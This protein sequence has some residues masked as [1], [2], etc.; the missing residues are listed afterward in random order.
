MRLSE[1]E[2]KLHIFEVLQKGYYFSSDLHTK[3]NHVSGRFKNIKN[4][5]MMQGLIFN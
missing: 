3:T 2:A 1:T 4:Y 5:D